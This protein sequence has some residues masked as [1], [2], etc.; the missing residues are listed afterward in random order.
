[1]SIHDR[2]AELDRERRYL[3]AD[4][5]E[6]RWLDQQHKEAKRPARRTLPP[7]VAKPGSYWAAA[8]FKAG[9]EDDYVNDMQARYGGEW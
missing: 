6:M 4:L 7:L 3:E 8:A 1:M 9:R 2:L 5:A